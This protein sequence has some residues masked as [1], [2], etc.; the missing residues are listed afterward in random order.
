MQVIL[1]GK[2]IEEK[3]ITATKHKFIG[4]FRRPRPNYE[5]HICTCGRRI[6][7]YEVATEH[8]LMGHNDIPQY[9]TT[10]HTTTKKQSKKVSNFFN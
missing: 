8:Y 1:D 3:E 5:L 6:D 2:W 4:M 9:V 7:T 10:E